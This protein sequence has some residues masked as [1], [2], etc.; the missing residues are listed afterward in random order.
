[1]PSILD[2]LT[3]SIDIMQVR[4]SRSRMAGEPPDLIVAPRL[5]H[6]R[7]LD[8]QRAGEAIQEGHRAVQRVAHNLAELNHAAT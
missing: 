8:F 6:F 1:L 5:A 2:V 7:M 4:I 3:T